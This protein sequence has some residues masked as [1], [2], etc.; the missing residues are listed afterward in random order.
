MNEVENPIVN[1]TVDKDTWS[2]VLESTKQTIEF[3]PGAYYDFD[4]VNYLSP[5]IDGYMT[6]PVAVY[7]GKPI[8]AKTMVFADISEALSTLISNGDRIIMYMLIY[9]PSHPVYSG[10]DE[11]TY[12]LRQLD[13]PTIRE[14]AW[15]MRFASV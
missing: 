8:E 13:T 12:M 10:I 4:G 11:E 15:K 5:V 2:K 3:L 1:T 7:N 9:I 14:G 6:A